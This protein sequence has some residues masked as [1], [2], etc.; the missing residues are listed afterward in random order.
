MRPAPPSSTICARRWAAERSS[1]GR[2]QRSSDAG[3]PSLWPPSSGLGLVAVA[4]VALASGLVGGAGSPSPSTSAPL[5][6][7]PTAA[8]AATSA[9]RRTLRSSPTRP[10][11][12]CSPSF[13]RTGSDL[14]SW[15][16]QGRHRDG[17]MERAH[18]RLEIGQRAEHREQLWAGAARRP[19]G[20]PDLQ[21]RRRPGSALHTGAPTAGVHRRRR[22]RGG[23]F[24]GC[25]RNALC[26][27]AWLVFRRRRRLNDVVRRRQQR[28]QRHGGVH[29]ESELG[30]RVD[31]STGPS[32]VA[33][34]SASPHGRTPTTTP[35][36]SGG[37][38]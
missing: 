8:P 3:P 13:P 33:T 16:G 5:A 27:Q 29:P 9:R 25:T 10:S 23:I 4:G 19:Q 22:G 28:V 38:T 36:T 11:R 30:R 14:R 37:R 26:H 2:S 15:W 24:C 1:L 17:G 35:C 32:R 18:H 6:A 31:G 21:T 7:A 12:H 34:H 20:I